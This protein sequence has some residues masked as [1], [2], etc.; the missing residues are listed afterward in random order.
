ML[1]Q[2]KKKTQPQTSHLESRRETKSE[3]RSMCYERK[4]KNNAVYSE[5]NLLFICLV[6]AKNSLTK[7]RYLHNCLNYFQQIN[8]VS[9]KKTEK[10]DLNMF[11]L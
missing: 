2:S 9:F 11:Q 10:I 6:H 1:A 8:L 7:N 4:P 3:Q 5:F